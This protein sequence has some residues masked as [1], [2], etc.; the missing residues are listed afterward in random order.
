MPY[1]SFIPV[2]EE[3]TGMLK[4]VLAFYWA[5]TAFTLGTMPAAAQLGPMCSWPFKPFPWLGPAFASGFYSLCTQG[6]FNNYGNA[7]FW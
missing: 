4:K 3:L 6:M 2:V 5:A 7:G 1:L